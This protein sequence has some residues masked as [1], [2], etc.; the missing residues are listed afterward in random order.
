[1]ARMMP[2]SVFRRVFRRIWISEFPVYI[3]FELI[4]DE[5]LSGDGVL[6]QI[7]NGNDTDDLIVFEY[8]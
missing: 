2:L 1:M 3:T 7:A 5:L 4:N 8:R 6:N